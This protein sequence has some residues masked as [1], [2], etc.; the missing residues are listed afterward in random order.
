[1]AGVGG[2]VEGL[3]VESAQSF[4]I[5]IQTRL[6]AWP[7]CWELVN[8]RYCRAINDKIASAK[9]AAIAV[10]ASNGANTMVFQL[11]S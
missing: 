7:S 6:S 3:K 11:R 1:M 8:G 2:L 10:T 4:K 5:E 9:A